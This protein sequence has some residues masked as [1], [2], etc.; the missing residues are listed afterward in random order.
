MGKFEGKVFLE[1]GTNAGSVEIVKYAK[2]EGAYVIVSDYLPPEK[3]EAKLYADDTAM[4]S[5]L[6]FDLLEQFAREKKVDG[7]FCGVSETNLKAVRE[8]THRLGLPCYFTKDQW[9]LCQD[10]AEF[11]D[12]CRKYD[13]P[14][15]KQFPI[16][17]PPSSEELHRLEYPVIV[18]PVDLGASRGIHI[19]HNEQELLEGYNDA[20]EKS[21]SKKIIVEEYLIGDEISATY[22]VIKGKC[23]LSMVS[24]MYYNREQKGLVPLPDA[25]IYPSKHLQRYI[26]EV[27]PKM[28][29]MIESIGYSDGT[30]F[31]TGIAREDRFAFFEAGL[32][33]AGTLPYLFISAVNGINIMQLMTE[34]AINGSISEPEKLALEDPFLKGKICCLFSLLNK[35]GTIAAVT[36]LDKI[37]DIPGVIWITEQRKIGDTIVSD[38]TL[39]QIHLRFYIVRE[40]VDEIRAVIREIRKN[41][42]VTDQNGNNMLLK[43]VADEII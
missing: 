17:N 18:K 1:L 26:K 35:G 28:R 32:R 30:I 38:G 7:I 29:E 16:S 42:F 5:T 2:S 24:Q 8:V 9:D 40:T 25:Y 6:D 33:M 27:D 11:K 31:I 14:I 34:Y 23:K 3:S 36:G 21:H 37:R 15:A 20:Y 10:K 12:L 41:V 43:S 13:V 22:T 19:C 4:I 39:G